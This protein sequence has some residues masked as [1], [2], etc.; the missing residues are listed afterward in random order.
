MNARDAVSAL[1]G[2]EAVGAHRIGGG[3]T[4][5][6]FEVELAGGD[7]VV[8]KGLT[9]A[10]PGATEC[11]AAGL[12]WLADGGAPVPPV[13][14]YD[15]AWLVM[16]YVEPG[17]PT[18]TAAERLG[19]DLAALHDS[20]APAHGAPPAPGCAQAWIGPVPMRNAGGTDWAEFYA[21]H[22]V[23][24][25]LRKAVDAGALDAAAAAE[26]ARA[27][28]AVPGAAGPDEPP[29]R[30]HGDLWSG[31]VHYST[32]DRAWLLDPAAHGGHRETDLAMLALFGAPYL[33]RV[34]AAY[35]EVSPLA[36]GWRDR[37]PLHQLFPLLVHCVVYGRSYAAQTLG[38]A[39]AV[40]ALR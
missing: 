10:T 18:A 23:R 22:R 9:A 14:A 1:L 13:R 32:D 27:A 12:A 35:Q 40:L 26:V 17:D 20:G 24:P 15:D 36:D 28:D 7:V 38:A 31:N 39:R 11:E 2:V 37:I 21:E 4:G 5:S 16:E 30:L 19:R 6:V 34:L 8:A 25:F 33:D 29:S 3:A